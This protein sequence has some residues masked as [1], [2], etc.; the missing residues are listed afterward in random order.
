L[1]S[2]TDHTEEPLPDFSADIHRLEHAKLVEG[3]PDWSLQTDQPLISTGRSET[4]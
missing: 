3:T 2:I 4:Q 1:K